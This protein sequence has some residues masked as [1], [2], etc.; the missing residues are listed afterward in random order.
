MP[1]SQE[2]GGPTVGYLCVLRLPLRCHD[3]QHSTSLRDVTTRAASKHDYGRR[4][5][6]CR[7]AQGDAVH[8]KQY[9]YL[10][11]LPDDMRSRRPLFVR[12]LAPDT[13]GTV[14]VAQ[15]PH[16]RH[17]RSWESSHRR[18]RRQVA[19]PGSRCRAQSTHHPLFNA[20]LSDRQ[21]Q[22]PPASLTDGLRLSGCTPTAVYAPPE[23][24]GERRVVA[25]AGAALAGRPACVVTMQGDQP[26]GATRWQRCG[27]GSRQ[28]RG[29][30]SS[31]P[32]NRSS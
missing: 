31:A 7:P 21:T 3:A 13:Q 8:S 18:C 4:S 9:K 17:T 12:C 16:M 32:D 14:E 15:C 22:R 10:Q 27:A 6:R 11:R 26:R 30:Q 1:A 23:P 25:A 19:G 24:D 28:H 20:P 5:W 29:C 2:R